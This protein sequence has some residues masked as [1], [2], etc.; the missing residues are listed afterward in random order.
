MK[1]KTIFV[2]SVIALAAAGG[3]WWLAQP[4]GAHKHQLEK[5]VDE[6]GKTYYTCAM[7]PEV[8]QSE[9]GNCPICGMKLTKR[10]EASAMGSDT[11]MAAGE[12]KPLYW[13]DPMVPDQ[14]FDAPGKSP[15]MDMQLV[16]KYA[17]GGGMGGAGTVV[18]IDPRMA[19]NLGVRV[20]PATLG[21]FFQRVEAVGSVA[22]DERRIVVVQSRTAGWIERLDVRAEGDPVKKGQRLAALYSPDLFAAKQELKLAQDS[23]DAALAKAS[24]QRLRLLGGGAG[25]GSQSGVFSPASGFVV[26]LMAREGAQLEPGMPLM[27]LADLSQVWINVEIPEVQAGWIAEGK[28][29]EARLKSLPGK[30][31]EGTVDYLYPQLDSGT[32][33]LRARL[34]FDNADGSL[35]PGMFADVSLFGGGQQD[36]LLVPSEA[37]IRTGERTVVLVA[38]SAGRYRPAAVETGPE[39]NDQTMILSGLE[40]GQNV[41]VSGQFLIDSEASLLGAYQRMG[42]GAG[43]A[44]GMQGMQDAP[45]MRG[46]GEMEGMTDEQHKEMHPGEAAAERPKAENVP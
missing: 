8:K 37:V 46:A 32:R 10:T 25:G 1:T 21:T 5:R 20:A 13:Y 28:S 9:P 41:V 24:Q 2:L 31:F 38:E 27:K 15:F 34:V 40:A 39:R 29:A 45:S 36:V 7:H 4:E 6:A 17:E 14:H 43:M 33:T 16:P 12:K 30:V 18:E 3:G 44:E 19:Q 35:R 22:L 23:G 26:E 11:A 42:A